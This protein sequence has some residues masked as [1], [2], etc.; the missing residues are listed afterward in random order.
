MGK[1]VVWRPKSDLYEPPARPRRVT[2]K[3]IDENSEPKIYNGFDPDE[4]TVEFIDIEAEEKP[5]PRI[6]LPRQER[7]ITQHDR[8]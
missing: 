3:R 7:K 6:R 4:Q 1:P 2:V 5:A 8:G